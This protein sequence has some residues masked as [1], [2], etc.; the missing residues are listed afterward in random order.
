MGEAGLTSS[1]GAGGGVDA[2]LD[3]ALSCEGAEDASEGATDE[4]CDD[5]SEEASED[6][7]VDA[8]DDASVEASDDADEA[9]SAESSIE[10]SSAGSNASNILSKSEAAK[11]ELASKA[12][13]LSAF[14]PHPVSMAREM[15]MT[16]TNRFFMKSPKLLIT[17]FFIPDLQICSHNLGGKRCT[18]VLLK[19][20]LGQLY[21]LKA[22]VQKRNIAVSDKDIGKI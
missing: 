2:S 20:L 18:V 7:S 9:D 10:A 14:L 19:M 17:G 13:S 15:I 6:A 22:D 4:A 8:S 1:A 12:A 11:A 3:A 5:V 16:A 21:I